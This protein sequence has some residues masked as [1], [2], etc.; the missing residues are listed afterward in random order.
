MLRTEERQRIIRQRGSKCECCGL[1]EWLGLPIKLEV[2]H[3]DGNR[4]NDDLDNLQVLCPNCHSYTNNHSKNIK[5]HSV[6]DEE[7]LEALQNA[8][9]IH[10]ALIKAGL[11]TAGANYNRA[12]KMVNDYGLLH[13]YKKITEN[14]CIDCGA[15]ITS[16]ALRCDRCHS[17]SVRVAERPSREQ[18]KK[19]IRSLPFT[20]IGKQYGVSDNAVRKWCDSYNLP[21][22]VSDIKKYS[23]EEWKKI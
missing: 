4:L 12:R 6:S 3:I 20:T 10:Q 16:N 1:T 19:E 14:Y 13:L 17:L 9:S 22:R 5:N 18:L 2:H 8:P 11:S 23:D 7:L 21:R 15:P